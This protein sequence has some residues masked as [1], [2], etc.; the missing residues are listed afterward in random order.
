[1]I[2]FEVLAAVVMKS[3]IFQDTMPCRP[4]KSNRRFGGKCLKASY[5][6]HTGFLLGL[7]FDPEVGGDMFLRNVG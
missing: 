4:L 2:G 5:L 3:S 1:M 7:F 6:F